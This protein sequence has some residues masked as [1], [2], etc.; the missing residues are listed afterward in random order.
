[1]SAFC[2]LPVFL[3]FCFGAGGGGVWGGG[4]ASKQRVPLQPNRLMKDGNRNEVDMDLMVAQDAC[5]WP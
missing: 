2:L 1:M 5:A 3:V 4:G